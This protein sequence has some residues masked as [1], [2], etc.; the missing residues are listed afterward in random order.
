MTEF[1]NFLH[2]RLYSFRVDLEEDVR[3]LLVKVPN[4]GQLDQQLRE[5]L[6]RHRGWI[7]GAEVALEKGGVSILL[8]EDLHGAYE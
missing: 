3:M 5:Q 4:V 1:Q 6:R 2:E 8:V 7:L